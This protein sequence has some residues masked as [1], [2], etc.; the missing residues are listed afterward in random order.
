MLNNVNEIHIYMISFGLYLVIQT[1]TYFLTNKCISSK[2]EKMK[3]KNI[4]LIEQKDNLIH[5]NSE[6]KVKNSHVNEKI[7]QIIENKELSALQY[8]KRMEEHLSVITRQDEKIVYLENLITNQD[9]KIM[10]LENLK[11]VGNNNQNMIAIKTKNDYSNNNPMLSDIIDDK[12]PEIKTESDNISGKY[13]II[14]G[15]TYGLNRKLKFKNYPRTSLIKIKD[16]DKNDKIQVGWFLP[17]TIK[18]A[19]QKTVSKMKLDSK[20]FFYYL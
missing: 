4:L 9:K 2:L 5:E 1:L 14:F 10:E 7:K 18:F 6:L 15:E 3:N 20:I 19:V 13:F 11:Q 16:K 17:T 8:R 12:L